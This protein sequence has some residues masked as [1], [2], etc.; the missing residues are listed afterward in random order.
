VSAAR[1][2]P[3]RVGFARAEVSAG[4]A[5]GLVRLELVRSGDLTAAE[6]KVRALPLSAREG[7]DFAPPEER[8]TLA[9]GT[10]R[11]EVM[12]QVFDNALADG[13]RRFAVALW[14]PGSGLAV[15][16]IGAVVVTLTDDETEVSTV[17]DTSFRA[18]P[19][20]DH[21][22]RTLAMLAGGDVVVGGGLPP[23]A[24]P[25]TRGWHRCIPM[26]RGWRVGP[27]VSIASTPPP[28][29]PMGG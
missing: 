23:S 27:K 10:E 25:F 16:P 22:V 3:G 15:G 8:V 12:L 17:L 24:A 5:A 11:V 21:E 13:P 19:G 1:E 6:V 14:E 20:A 26:V 7:L 29:S 4:E 2:P 18:R 9:A 28:C